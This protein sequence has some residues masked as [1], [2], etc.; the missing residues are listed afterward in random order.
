M[1][2][3]S[4]FE[5]ADIHQW[6]Q[7]VL[8]DLE[9]NDI[10]QIT[11]IALPEGIIQSPYVDFTSV[12]EPGLKKFSSDITANST[13]GRQWLNLEFITA[14]NPR[15]ANERAQEALTAGA[16]GIIFEVGND[17]DFPLLFTDISLV[18][19]FLGLKG[20]PSG[21]RE[22]LQYLS[23]KQ[24]DLQGF[25]R[26]PLEYSS[27]L[28]NHN[29]RFRNLVVQEPTPALST[30]QE[31]SRLLSQ[32][33][34]TID[35]LLISEIPKEIVF[36]NIQFVLTLGNSFLWEICRLRSLRILFH[37]VMRLYGVAFAP[38]TIA[39][40]VFTSVVPESNV[41]PLIGSTIQA[42]SAIL[43]GCNSLS[44]MPYSHDTVRLTR[45]VS[46]ILK[47]ECYLNQVR[48]PI[49]GSYYMEDLTHKMMKN[50]CSGFTDLEQKGGFAGASV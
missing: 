34:H 36:N 43:G 48:D 32:A 42:M 17:P 25:A 37:Q 29:G 10:R 38:D 4:D 28:Q 40:H 47:E 30:L 24:T 6:E 50:I 41:H 12:R 9:I 19:C 27:G 13:D 23:S 14:D 15:T 46:T 1:P 5:F 45:N 44:V 3:L 33:V 20:T 8:A 11:E 16:D 21:V 7:Q 2:D 31:I 49:A 39:I 22:G 18:H 35:T 26:I